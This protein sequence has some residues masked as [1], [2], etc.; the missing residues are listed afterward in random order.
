MTVYI[1]IK[2][3]SL[4][5][6]RLHWRAMDRLKR[7]QKDAVFIALNSTTEQAPMFPVVVTIKRLGKRRMDSDNNVISAKYI[8]DSIAKWLGIDDGREDLYEWRYEQA[9]DTQYG[10][11]IRIEAR[12]AL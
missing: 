1:P 9:I 2:L 6:M 5:N 10:V 12:E 3:P 8:R 4:A 7:S 11:E